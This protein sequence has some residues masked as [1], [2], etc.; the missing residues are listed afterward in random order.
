LRG[1]RYGGVEVHERTNLHASTYVGEA[2]AE[3][4]RV[5][6]EPKD[7]RGGRKPCAF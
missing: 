5:R 4:P 7:E 6:G 3:D 2:G 1:R